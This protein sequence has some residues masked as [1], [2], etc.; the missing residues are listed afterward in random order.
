MIK[1]II[2]NTIKN[3]KDVDNTKVRNSYIILT[4]VLGIIINIFLF[5]LKLVIGLFMN[6]VAI[7]SDSFNNLFDT[8]VSIVAIIGVKISNKPPDKEHPFGHGRSEYI[9]TLIVSIIIIIVGVELFR[10]AVERIIKPEDIQF[11]K[12]LIIILIIS[13]LLKLWMYFYNNYMARILNSDLNKGLAIDSRNDILATSA[14]ITSAIISHYTKYNIDAIAGFTVSILVLYSGYSMAKEAISSL[15]GEVP[16]SVVLEKIGQIIKSGK[17]VVGYHDL[18]VHD[19]GH[20][21][22]LAVAHVETPE[23]IRAGIM[24]DII[25]ELEN[26]VKEELGIELVIHADPTYTVVKELYK[27]QNEDD[28]LYN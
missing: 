24:H 6:S 25:D 1:L 18:E 19:Y 2:R 21:K 20:G 16:N 15:L 9:S 12:I 3:Y 17:Y 22:I 23:N 27:G 26:Q 11:N 7:I 5:T 13:L 10:N 14:I 8:F 28:F 4:G